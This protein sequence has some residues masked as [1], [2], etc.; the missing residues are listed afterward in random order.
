MKHCPFCGGQAHV[1]RES[2]IWGFCRWKVRCELCEAQSGGYATRQ[3]AMHGWNCRVGGEET[4]DG[5][6]RFMPSSEACMSGPWNH[7]GATR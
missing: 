5:L 4:D 2:W 6:E 7:S 1:V 3:D